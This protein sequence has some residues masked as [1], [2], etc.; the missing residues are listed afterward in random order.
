M[1]KEVKHDV[2]LPVR[3]LSGPAEPIGYRYGLPEVSR[4]VPGA[5]G[6]SRKP[7]AV[8]QKIT[9]PEVRTTNLL[10]F[11]GLAHDNVAPPDTNGAVG[12]TQFVETVNVQYAV[13]DKTTGT[14]VQGPKTLLSI[15]SGFGGLCQNGPNSSDPIVLYDKAAGRWMI[16]YL[17]YTNALNSF[18]EC[19]AVSTSSD[20]TGSYNRYAYNFGANLNDYPKFGVW[21]D[22][23]YANYNMFQNAAFF[24]G[25]QACAYDRAAML[26]G[27]TAN[28][29]CFQQNSLEYTMLPADLDG[30]TAPPAGPP[31]PYFDVFSGTQLHRHQF[32]VDWVN[33]NNSTFSTG[34]PITIANWT[35]LCPGTRACVTEPSPGEAVDSIGNRLMFRNAYRNLGDH[36]AVVL[37]HTVA[38]GSKTAVRW[39]EIRTPN[40]TPSLFQSGTVS[41]APFFWM[42]AIAMDKLGNIALLFNASSSTIKP[43]VA[44]VG[45]VPTDPLGTMESPNKVK[46]GTGVQT[47]TSNRWG[48]YSGLAID[49]ADDCT[50]WGSAEYYATTG[51]FL[52][53]TRIVKFKF[54]NCN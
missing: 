25:A 5:L 36:E 4:I 39:Y 43:S 16:S 47:N 11:D 20:A 23:Y 10:N 49:P 13:Y 8:L 34:T 26:A 42:P 54:N 44:Y 18:F 6:D 51:S 45:R 19:I 38:S 28:S 2:S 27:N 15:F 48:D 53:N 12:G 29:V 35:Q 3:N 30:N 40:G 52:W 1:M 31:N 17:A 32:H 41:Q 33:P 46:L 21:P 14:Q 7:D 22:G 9:L 37:T 50:F 24:I